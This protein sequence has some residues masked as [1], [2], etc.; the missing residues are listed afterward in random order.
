LESAPYVDITISVLGSYGIFVAD[1]GNGYSIAGG[2]IIQHD[3]YTVEG[4]Y[5]QAAFFLAGAAITGDITAMNLNID[6][7]QGD[8]K[9]VELLR[10]FGADIKQDGNTVACGSEELHG[11]DIDASQIPDLV[12]ILAVL[13]AYAAGTTR[14]YNAARLK[15][16]ESDRLAAT[17]DMLTKLGAEIA[18]TEDG[19][20]ITEKGKLPGGRCSAWNDH[21]IAMAA[22]IAGACSEKGAVIEDYECVRKSY[23]G[24]FEDLGRLGGN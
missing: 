1:V 2:H 5:S 11:I 17:S 21:R 24:F 7:R 23:P 3:R 13:G 10:E 20:I 19:L 6:S 15:L 4:D 16:K 9:I 14:I 12:P 18:A 8:K 22:A